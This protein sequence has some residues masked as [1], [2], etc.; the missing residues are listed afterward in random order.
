MV[1]GTLETVKLVSDVASNAATIAAVLV[2]G[3]WTYWAFVRE[4]TRWP[5]ANLELVMSHRE[6]SADKT[7]LHVKVKVN[8]SGR[9]LM[10]LTELW[11]DVRRVL[12][13]S[14]EVAEE[15]RSGTLIAAE[16]GKA[17]WRIPQD[18]QHECR[19]GPGEKRKVE[20]EIEP[21]E[22]D[23]FPHDFIVPS[24]LRTVYIYVHVKN[25]ARKGRDEL[26]W[27]V[28]SYYDLAGTE[29][30]DSAKNM[31]AAEAG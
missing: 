9:G 3:F 31:I 13:L 25:E 18:C 17:G 19:W 4:R 24:T 16:S 26:G 1:A 30:G 6:L 11:V 23:E 21:G 7:L 29:G 14:D 8:N 2:G 5:R 12:P 27:T 10:K 20:P 28:S 22:N 15:L